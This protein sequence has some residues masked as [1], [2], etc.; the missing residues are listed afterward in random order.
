[1]NEQ[2]FYLGMSLEGVGRL[3]ETE[4]EVLLRQQAVLNLSVNVVQRGTKRSVCVC[5][6]CVCVCV[7]VCV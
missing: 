4:E 3:F 1:V 2:N 6:W 7:C 5:V